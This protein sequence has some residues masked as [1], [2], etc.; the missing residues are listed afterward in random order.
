MA[1]HDIISIRDSAPPPSTPS[2]TSSGLL[3]AGG[4]A[5]GLAAVLASSCCAIP[6]LLAAMGAGA[7]IFTGL[8]ALTSYRLPLIAFGGLAVAGGWWLRWRK[9]LASCETGAA[10][11][12]A[13]RSR[14]T[15]I[16]LCVATLTVVVA[17]AWDFIEPALLRL[18]GIG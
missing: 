1:L 5:F 13:T 17:M 7:G 10:C 3:A 4:A 11:A 15:T 2:A 8:D 18:M 12:V 9:G 6:F 16:M 14:A